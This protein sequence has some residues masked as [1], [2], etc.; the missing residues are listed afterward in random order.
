MD[1]T[2][3][4]HREV[5]RRTGQQG[6]ETSA[7]MSIPA[8]SAQHA[9]SKVLGPYGLPTTRVR[10]PCPFSLPARGRGSIQLLPPQTILGGPRIVLPHQHSLTAQSDV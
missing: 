6:I 9:G 1:T 7:M 8:C 2:T 10:P 5:P 4:D 3:L